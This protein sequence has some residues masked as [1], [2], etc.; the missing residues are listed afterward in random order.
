MQAMTRGAPSAEHML[1][2]YILQP[3]KASTVPRLARAFS[4]CTDLTLFRREIDCVLCCAIQLGV[5]AYLKYHTPAQNKGTGTETLH[6][7]TSR[8]R[9]QTAALVPSLASEAAV[10]A[11]LQHH[12]IYGNAL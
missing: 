10:V 1:A 11:L 5:K 9:R 4:Y 8:N 3:C 12:H 6:T 2:R 7:Y